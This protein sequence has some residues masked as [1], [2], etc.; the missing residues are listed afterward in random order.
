MSQRNRPVRSKTAS[1]DRP[2][3]RTAKADQPK[4]NRDGSVG[5]DNFKQVEALLKQGKNKTEAFKQVAA[6]T[7]KNS[8]TVAANY[9]RVARTK[10]AVKPRKRLAKAAP[11]PLSEAVRRPLRASDDLVIPDQATA[12]RAWI[13][14]SASSWRVCR[15]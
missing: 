4:S 12:L 7:G 1:A 2:P 13:K 14:S 10:G 5:R 3:S 9:Y 6:D 11:R 15:R 8:G